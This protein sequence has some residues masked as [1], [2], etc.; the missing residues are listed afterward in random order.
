MNFI[1]RVLVLNFSSGYFWE[2]E[3]GFA[4]GSVNLST[5]QNLT[6]FLTCQD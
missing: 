1:Y 3:G 2:F 4:L 6:V 5:C